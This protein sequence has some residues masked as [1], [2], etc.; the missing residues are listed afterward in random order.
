M[1]EMQ[2][3]AFLAKREMDGMIAAAREA[4]KETEGL[5]ADMLQLI[6]GDEPPFQTVANFK[7]TKSMISTTI[8]SNPTLRYVNGGGGQMLFSGYS[9]DSSSSQDY[10][11]S[12]WC[13]MQPRMLGNVFFSVK[14]AFSIFTIKFFK[15]NMMVGVMSGPAP[16]GLGYDYSGPGSFTAG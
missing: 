15:E 2:A 7:V 5:S 11:A 4:L 3:Y 9:F 8:R 16:Y 12:G 10:S 13:F 6:S 14:I 1:D